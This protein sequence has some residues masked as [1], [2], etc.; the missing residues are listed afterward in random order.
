MKQIFFLVTMIGLL[1]AVGFGQG[2]FDNKK[3]LEPLEIDDVVVMV[4]VPVLLDGAM[5]PDIP[6]EL[7]RLRRID[8]YIYDSERRDLVTKCLAVMVLPKEHVPEFREV[9]EKYNGVREVVIEELSVLQVKY[10]TILE[11]VSRMAARV[12]DAELS[13]AIVKD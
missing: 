3:S 5:R 9:L 12:A 2:A 4:E 1:L 11:D 13:I 8:Y 7:R 6:A 10:P